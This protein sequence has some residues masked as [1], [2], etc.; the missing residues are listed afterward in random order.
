MP[1]RASKGEGA[2][3]YE[4]KLRGVAKDQQKRR[5]R[6]AQRHQ[7]GAQPGPRRR[8]ARRQDWQDAHDAIREEQPRARA[9][10][11][12]GEDTAGAATAGALPMEADSRFASAKR[13]RRRNA[14]V[15]RL[16]KTF[17]GAVQL[18]GRPRLPLPGDMNSREYRR[19]LECVTKVLPVKCKVEEDE[20]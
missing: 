19:A 4:R 11:S 1:K 16:S 14:E 13:R 2:H 9:R 10:L 5:H 7:A 12:P 17:D 20:K 18:D 3:W 15:N 6:S 8:A